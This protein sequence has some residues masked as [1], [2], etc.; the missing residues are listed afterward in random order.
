MAFLRR[1]AVT[2]LLHARPVVKPVVING[3][4]DNVSFGD[5]G[6]LESVRHS[7]PA[8][9]EPVTGFE[10]LEFIYRKRLHHVGDIMHETHVSQH[11]FVYGT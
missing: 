8:E 4:I 6:R 9:L 3:G 10:Q 2:L 7:L 11:G 5:G 1:H